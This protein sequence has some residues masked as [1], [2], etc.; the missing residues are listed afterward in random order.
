[1]TS[2][3]NKTA[4]VTG[5]SRGIGRAIALA[6]ATEGARVLLHYGRSQQEADAVVAAIRQSGGQAH[7]LGADL[8]RPEG[9]ALLAQQ[10]EQLVGERLDIA[11]LNA[12]VS[13]AAPLAAYQVEDLDNLYATNVRGP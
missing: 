6:L 10:V 9:A 5:A 12:G 7:A 8:A 3:V 1:M 4:L 13:K 11:V 2:L